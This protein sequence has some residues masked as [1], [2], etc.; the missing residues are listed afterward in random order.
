MPAVRILQGIA[1]DDFSWSPGQIVDM[2]GEEVA[3]W[4]DGYRAE[5]VRGE[6]PETPERGM[7]EPEAADDGDAGEPE[8]ASTK[9]RARRSKKPAG[10]D[11]T[12][13]PGGA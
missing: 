4:C 9:P 8:V 13:D 11:P 3:Q 1:G 7:P 12:T 2:P 10:E 5:L 6:A